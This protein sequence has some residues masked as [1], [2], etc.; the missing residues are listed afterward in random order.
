MMQIFTSTGNKFRKIQQ[1]FSLL[2]LL[3]SIALL[4]LVM[5]LLYGAFFQI[6]NSSL[7]VKSTLETRQELRLLMK[8][9]L[10]DLQNVQYLKSFA[11]SGQSKNPQ[12]ESGMI[13]VSTLGPYNPE[14]G[15]LV[16]VSSIYFHTA[17]KSRFYPEEKEQDPELH[18]VSYTMQ[19]NLD[20]KIWEFVRREDFYLDNNLREGGKSYVLSEAVTKFELLLLES[21]TALAGGGYQEKWTREWD[22]DEENCIGTSPQYGEPFCLPR[23]VKLTMALKGS[24]GNTVTDSQV[25]NLCVPPCNPEIFE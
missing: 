23:S 4:G 11:E 14:T 12:L 17:I 18:E 20:T 1:G 21:E 8:M 13:A 16:E 5:S 2:E 24:N 9:V 25:S 7:Q 6:S 22:S 3:I 10:D 19:E 15:G